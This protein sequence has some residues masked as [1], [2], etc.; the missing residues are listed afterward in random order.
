MD[1][2]NFYFRL[3]DEMPEFVRTKDWSA[4]KLGPREQWSPS[5]GMALEIVLASAFPMA[6][7]W[8][9]DFVL[10]YNDG[11]R[12]I[13]GEKHPWAL[14]RT[15]QE[16]WPELWD[17]I[18]PAHEA[19][20]NGRHKAIFIEETKLRIQRNHD[21]WDDASFTLSYSPTPDATSP[22]GIGGVFVTALETTC[23]VGTERRLREVQSALEAERA[24][25]RDLFQHAPS[26]MAVLHGPEHRFEFANDS[27]QRLIGHRQVIG[28]PVREALP[29]FAGQGFFEL[30]DRVYASG[31]PFT[32]R[33]ML[34]NLQR[35]PG[36][37][38]KA[39]YIDV[40]YQPI[41][42]AD[43]EVY[44]IFVDGSDITDR[45]AAE[46][47]LQRLNAMLE[48]QVTARTH[49]RNRLWQNSQDLLSVVD[50]NGVFR[51]A[52]P[53]WTSI[54]GWTPEEIIGRAHLDFIHPDD[55]PASE[56]ALA[57][58]LD[59]KLPAFENRLLHKDGSYRWVSWVAT[60]EA[61]LVYASGRHVTA[62]K[63]AAG[64]LARAQDALRQAYKM[65]AIGQLTG[66]IA[67]DFNNMLAIVIGSLD[68]A[69]RRLQRGDVAV[70]RYLDNANEGAQRA[71]TLTRRL[72]AF[73]RQ[74]Q[75]APQAIGLNKLVECMS[76]LLRRTLG[77]RVDLETTLAADLWP[78]NVDPNQLESAV[79]NLAVNAR[80]AMPDGGRLTIET[81][82]VDLN[83]RYAAQEVG[84]AP[85]Q[86]V[87]IAVSDVGMG[88]PAELLQ[89]VFDPFFTTKPVGKGTGL[90]LSMVYGFA[91]QSGG[92]VRIYSAPGHGTTVK[93][94]LPRHFGSL[95]PLEDAT[96]PNSLLTLGSSMETVLIVED[97]ESV[98]RM[99]ID[100]LLELG[101]TVYAA[102]S[103]EE[104]LTV[105]AN[106]DRIDILF[107]D[108][109]MAGMT[110]RQLADTLRTKCPEL[111]V[112]YT[113]GYMRNYMTYS[114]AFD[115]GITF[116]PK[117]FSVTELAVKLRAV[118]DG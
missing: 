105:F 87:G 63:A 39:V 80:D 76:E 10:L 53:G 46:E 20:L 88:M 108:V 91:R 65:E 68:L 38:M 54:L 48:Q 33:R 4:T 15:A 1:D 66:G 11:F 86:Y 72:L 14:G 27:Y 24:F 97:E 77:E 41:R 113:T 62:E 106:A 31:E 17:Q 32:G 71:A 114:D 12:I 42:N 5:L 69:K 37:A 82:N 6:L 60:R 7:R 64:E 79:L 52:S 56:D 30:L 28:R 98:R 61:D 40:M 115:P 58:A 36:A 116:L 73:S 110:G 29:E 21:S 22:T 109:V 85:G 35:Q 101:Y 34:T 100:A 95:A 92:H 78:A 19:I 13:L 55:R 16:V 74:S 112:L 25:L 45:V 75:L 67:H 8:G 49:E 107:T 111:K 23:R 18:G 47:A 104:A 50:T 103:G 83:D 90:G 96:R 51:E 43:G 102:A 70:E 57:Q 89:K 93:I 84:V 99:S 94:Y 59:E 44:G 2:I 81:T 9:P 3:T 117:P 118:L 26:F